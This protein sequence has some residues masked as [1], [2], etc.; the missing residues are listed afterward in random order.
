MTQP[1]LEAIVELIQQD[2]RQLKEAEKTFPIL[3]E[4]WRQHVISLCDNS[5]EQQIIDW[6]I[7]YVPPSLLIE[8]ADHA[9][10]TEDYY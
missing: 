8:A 9:R 3:G 4:A 5:V 2:R 1:E 7:E 6:L 10:K